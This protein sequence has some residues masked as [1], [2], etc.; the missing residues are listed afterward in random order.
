MSN[1]ALH[2]NRSMTIGDFLS[3]ADRKP[4]HERWE[5][6]DGAPVMMVGGTEG[7][8]LIL[9]NLLTSSRVAS[10][11]AKAR[12]PGHDR[13]VHARKRRLDVRTGRGHPL[14]IGRSTRTL[15]G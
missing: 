7:H 14:R 13:F 6:L 9:G 12:M 2:Q 11:G 1:S 4:K 15:R 3:F 10:G 5:L 8:A